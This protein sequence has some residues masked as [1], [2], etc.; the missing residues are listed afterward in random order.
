MLGIPPYYRNALMISLKRG[1][2]RLPLK[3]LALALGIGVFSGSSAMA[4]GDG[5]AGMAQ[6]PKVCK[7]GLG[8]HDRGGPGF[9]TLGYGGPGLYPGFQGFGLGYHPGY[10]YGG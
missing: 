9:G 1:G 6:G 7:G 8:H 10:G 2:G 5:F 3:A 4:D